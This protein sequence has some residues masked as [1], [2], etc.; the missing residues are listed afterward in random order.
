MSTSDTTGVDR[1]R[2]R[3]LPATLLLLTATTGLVDAVSYL[4]LGHVFTANMT[5]NIV[6][7][8]FG[9]AGA[10][11]LSVSASLIALSGFL[12]GAVIGGRVATV[13]ER[14]SRRAWL[15]TAAA[16]ETGLLGIATIF[17]IGLPLDAT[18]GRRWPVVLTTALAMGIRNSTV[19]RLAEADLT[20]TVLTL[21]LTGIAADS[22]LAGGSNPRPTRRIGS[23]VAMLVGALAGAYLVL[24]RG[25]AWPLAIACACAAI[26]TAVALLAPDHV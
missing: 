3:P 6:F 7:L 23:V 22:W 19:R 20:T 13:L 9:L 5:G 16:A 11:G 12:A 15:V 2:I 14:D 18:I 10:K 24:H 26:A 25:P 1:R 4:G 8:A 17:A 21:T